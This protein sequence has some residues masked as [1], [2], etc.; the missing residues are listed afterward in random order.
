MSSFKY[1]IQHLTISAADS[2]PRYLNVSQY[3]KGRTVDTSS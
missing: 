3:E 1:V 2:E